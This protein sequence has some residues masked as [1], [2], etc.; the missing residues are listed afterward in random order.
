MFKYFY[1]KAILI[2]HFVLLILIQPVFSEETPPNIT[3]R[4]A[5]SIGLQQ[6][7]NKEYLSAEE[8]R[9]EFHQK[10]L[11]ASTVDHQLSSRLSFLKNDVEDTHDIEGSASETQQLK[12]SYQQKFVNS[13][14]WKVSAIQR[15]EAPLAGEAEEDTFV[16]LQLDASYGILG[17]AAN[18]KKLQFEKQ[19]ID[20]ESQRNAWQQENILLQ[21]EIARDF[22]DFTIMNYEVQET[23]KYLQLLY[24]KEKRKKILKRQISAL[25][26]KEL[27]L[28]ILE[29]EMDHAIQQDKYFEAKQRMAYHIGNENVQRNPVFES[30]FEIKQTQEEITQTYL[31]KSIKLQK[32]DQQRKLLIKDVDIAKQ[33]MTP[34]VTVGGNVGQSQTSTTSGQNLGVYV[35]FLYNFGGGRS[36]QVGVHESELR[37]LEVDMKKLKAELSLEA[38]SDYQLLLSMEKDIQIRQQQY[39]LAEEKMKIAQARFYAGELNQDQTLRFHKD[40]LGSQTALVR[41][42]TMFWEQYL[43]ILEKMLIAPL[44]I[45]EK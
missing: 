45:M 4:E 44:S 27:K 3:L 15:S 29:A 2:F 23:S 21:I 43:V 13:F 41:S 35:S 25:E 9:L 31:E 1:H 10:K 7:L 32:L 17:K 42:Q 8:N 18:V 26:M 22:F 30:D 28:E 20:L 39:Q 33:E 19:R 6:Q 16:K 14:T 37:K 38:R 12:A 40:L 24:Q 5:I 34:E 11:D 36:E